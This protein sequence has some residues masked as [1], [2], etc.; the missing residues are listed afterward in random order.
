MGDPRGF[1]KVKREL[2][3]Y[4]PKEQAS[5]CMDCGTPFCNWGCP[6]GNYIPEWNDYVF[7]DLWKKAFELLD[8]IN[9]MPEIT[10]R[11]CPAICEYACVLGINDDPVTISENELA[12]IKYAFKKGWIKPQPPLRRSGKKIA[13]I[14][15][16]PAGLSCAVQLNKLGHNV[17]VFEKDDKIGGLLRYGIPDFKL[18]KRL[19]ERRIKIWK[20]EGIKFVT[21]ANVGINYKISKLKKKFDVICLSGGSR[22]PR[23]LKIEGRDLGGIHF[24][25]DY[26]TDKRMDAKDKKV[27]II[28]GGDTGAD[29]AGTANRQGARH[30]VQ[31]EVLSKPPESRTEDMLWPRYPLLFKKS[32]EKAER[33]W[34]VKTEK[35]IGENGRVKGISGIKDGHKFEAEAELVIL[36]IGF[37]HPEHQGLIKNLGVKLDE[38]GNVRTD[39][40]YMTSRKGIFCAGD[41]RRGQSLIVWAVSEGIEAANCIDRYLT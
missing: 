9:P 12:I 33:H 23:D 17:T 29:C 16:G 6:I 37:V 14:G 2:A 4:K 26:L 30:V 25:M 38:R 22:V 1:L 7:K 31:I 24:A 20:K 3:P 18:E 34:S 8:A 32:L 39:E 10:A 11:L 36:A 35:F 19:I 15:S 21:N 13:V 5:R 41:M 27:L 28:G 40:N